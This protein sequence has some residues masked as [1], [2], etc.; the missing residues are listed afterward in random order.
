MKYLL[1]TLIIFS[2]I[3]SYTQLSTTHYIPPFYANPN[4]TSTTAQEQVLYLSTP[5]TNANY[6]ITDGNGNVLQAGAIQNGVSANYYMSGYGTAFICDNNELNQIHTNK[7]LIITSDSALYANLRVNAGNS[8]AQAGS[9]TSKGIEAMG[10][11]YRLGHFPSPTRSGR[12]VSG[13]GIMAT[14]NAT[15]ITVDFNS[16]GMV[17][18]GAGAPSSSVPLVIT[19]NAGESYVA[20]IHSMDSK[21]NLDTGL[22]GTLIT[23]NKPIAVNTGSWAGSLRTS[24]GADIGIDQIVDFSMVGD[25]YVTVR[26]QGAGTD[27]DDQE[28]V[29]IVAHLDNTEIFI[30]DSLIAIDTL[31]AG[32]YRLL[33]GAFY[34]NDV[35]YIKT[36][37]PSYVYQFI[38]GKDN[39]AQ[40]QGMNFVP[41]INCHTAE[42]INSIP[43]IEG[44]G[45][46][47]YTGGITVVTKIGS[48]IL[49][50][51]VPPAVSPAPALGS[52]Y[53]AYKIE[54]LTGD[55]TVSSNSIALVGFFGVSGAAGYGG[56]YSGFNRLEL[57]SS[58][59]EECTPGA[60]ITSSNLNGAYQWYK[61]GIQLT[62]ET[63]DTLNFSTEGDYF[64]VFT[65]EECK[66][67]S[68]IISILPIPTIDL[69]NDFYLC[70]GRDSIVTPITANGSTLLWF[71][72]NSN[73]QMK[74]DSAGT[75]WA[76]LKNAKDCKTNDTIIVTSDDLT[77]I[78]T[79]VDTCS[80][81][82]LT[83]SS[84]LTGSFQWYNDGGAILGQ[85]N[86]TLSFTEQGDYFV[87]FTN[88]GC[89]DTSTTTQIPPNPSTDLG[90]DF[91]ICVTKDTIITALYSDDATAAWFATDT[92]DAIT[93]NTSGVFW[94]ELTSS[95]GCKFTDTLEVFFEDCTD[96][97]TMP[98]VLTPNNDG[99]NDFFKPIE[100]KNTTNPVLIIYNR[101]GIKLATIHN[102]ET[103]WNGAIDGKKVLS[104]T[105][106]W[107]LEYQLKNLSNVIIDQRI[108]GF[109][110]VF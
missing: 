68:A 87:I 8:A 78:S 105:Y 59:L 42:E 26:G 43:F 5:H 27:D 12:K 4:F 58:V 31:S 79:A 23:S 2:F 98:N 25:E 17:F 19:L 15:T 77:F 90:D 76:E 108:N 65:K 29:M 34:K 102:L 80:P 46:Q 16:N 51:G 20:A 81:G 83:T 74:I 93:I 45:T 73:N 110:Q 3:T 91:T 14:Q 56:Y 100:S 40:T 86:E 55:V 13:Y 54:N 28:Q 95:K 63:A 64:S 35:M 38:S 52:K 24:S 99:I 36:S 32:E 96:L 60:L 61:D 84:N 50:N 33:D 41:P 62:S 94:V 44:I 6:T 21:N 82:I 10:T 104:G 57:T 53:E 88:K 101:W 22:I 109:I 71:G 67:T 7:G 92:N 72:T 107:T 103:G 75:Y 70:P 85:T 39:T 106:F 66:D 1:V 18:H 47:T 49:I 30:N 69:G 11:T 97:L 48:I 9:L 37:E 89:K